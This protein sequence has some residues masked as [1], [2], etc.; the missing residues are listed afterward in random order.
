M[1]AF[2]SLRLL[3]VDYRVVSTLKMGS[4]PSLKSL[5][6]SSL[7]DWA[8]SEVVKG[9]IRF[10]QNPEGGKLKTLELEM[11][12]VGMDVEDGDDAAAL[13][14]GF[15][16]FEGEGSGASRGEEKVD[17]LGELK[18]FRATG[19]GWKGRIRVVRDLAADGAWE[20][21]VEGERWGVVSG[22]L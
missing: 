2:N 20:K 18:K 6:L 1:Y 12:S 5:I 9:I 11:S 21:G 14:S 10:L 3:R 22:E 19:V 17:I 15:T 4:L 7:P 13:D 8:A 16:F